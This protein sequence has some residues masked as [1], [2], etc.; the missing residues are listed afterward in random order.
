MEGGG[1]RVEWDDGVMLV[2]VRR[3]YL[4]RKKQRPTMTLQ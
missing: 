1:A 2:W 4:A 3:R